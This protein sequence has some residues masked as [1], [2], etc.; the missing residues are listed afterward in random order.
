MNKFFI[1]FLVLGV[2]LVS[3]IFVYKGNNN[4][5]DSKKEKVVDVIKKESIEENISFEENT[6]IFSLAKR[7][8]DFKCDFLHNAPPSFS[9]GV[10]Y[11]SNN[12]VKGE[13]VSNINLPEYGIS[14]EIKSYMISDGESVYTWTSM[15]NDGYK[16][17]INKSATLDNQEVIQMDYMN[18]DLNYK[19]E[20]YNVDQSKFLLPT[21]ITFKKI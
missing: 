10:V 3:Y 11:I 5:N 4:S 17:S 18:E 20:S 14:N 19:C 2:V 12:K 6:N 8:G 15:S 7:G 16:A 1:G 9:A 13:F 21:N